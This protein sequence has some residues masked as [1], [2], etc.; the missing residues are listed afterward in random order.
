M[1]RA[2]PARVTPKS[3]MAHKIWAKARPRSRAIGSS[4]R[5]LRSPV[6]TEPPHGALDGTGRVSVGRNVE[7]PPFVLG[8]RRK[9]AQP[10]G[11]GES[12]AGGGL[13]QALDPQRPSKPDLLAEDPRRQP[14]QPRDLAAA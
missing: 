2:K 12:R 8:V 7:I 10:H 3:Q 5:I 14:V 9:Q 1:L 13:R 4:R 11:R 6:V